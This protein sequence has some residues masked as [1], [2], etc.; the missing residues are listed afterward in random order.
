MKWGKNV[1]EFNLPQNL[2]ISD[3]KNELM[4]TSKVNI[5]EQKLILKGK[6]LTDTT[7][8]S[9][10]PN[11]PTISMLGA[12][13]PSVDR[14]MP[15]PSKVMFVED[16]TEEQKLQIQREK[17]EE[18]VF[19]LTNLGNT[20]YLNATVQCIGRVPELRSALIKFVEDSSA[21]NDKSVPFNF[22]LALGSTYKS[23]D[24]ATDAVT[25][26]TLVDS[27]RKLNPMFGE[28]E[29]GVHKQQ[30]ADECVSL[31]MNTI[32]VYLKTENPDEAFSKNLIDEL[33][34]IEMRIKLQCVESE[35][36]VKTKQEI[37]S[38]L[39]CYIDSNTLELVEGLKKSLKENIDLY[40]ESLARN[41]IFEK[42]QTINR[43]PKYLTVQFM[44]FFWKAANELTGAK[45]GKAKILKSVLFSK[46]IDLYDMCADDTKELLNLGRKI[47]SKMLK[48]D[49]N[50]KIENVKKQP[51]VDMIPTGRYQ[52][53]SLIT[54]QG[55][56]SES[57][58]YIGWVHKKDD[59]WL[60]Y[61]DDTVSM[62]TTNDILELKGGGDWHMAYICFFKQLEVPFMEVFD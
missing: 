12:A 7:P 44:R 19:G 3:L 9:A 42:T 51:G 15:A 54:H 58:H 14:P 28:A 20:C 17:G 6:T 5:A 37:V 27:I 36:E 2:F 40:S 59:K 47:E 11:N 53:I 45:A 18:I 35:T 57:G 8:L 29:N 34:G 49:R 26:F 24:K 16:L 13:P 23:L 52:L 33:F 4:N 46:V 31:I 30:D 48:D 25:P 41:S 39:I 60:K 38:K 56:S 22:T 55:R 32:K 1:Y 21:T 61:D 43:L 10:L 62:V 50:F